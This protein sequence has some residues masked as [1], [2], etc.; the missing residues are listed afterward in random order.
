[1][2]SVKYF[3]AMEKHLIMFFLRKIFPHTFREQAPV[4]GSALAWIKE[5]RHLSLLQHR[6]LWEKDDCQGLK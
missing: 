1:V 2:E 3:Y 4:A 6:T 5:K